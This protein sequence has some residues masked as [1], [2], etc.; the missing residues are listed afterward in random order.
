MVHIFPL[1][2][3]SLAEARMWTIK[4]L[5]RVLWSNIMEEPPLVKVVG[6]LKQ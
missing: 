6:S 1:C 4:V 3:A 5:K 2:V